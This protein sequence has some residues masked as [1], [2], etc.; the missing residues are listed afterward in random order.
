M[1]KHFIYRICFAEKNIII[2]IKLH[3]I[4]LSLKKYHVVL[5]FAFK[6]DSYL[7]ELIRYKCFF[8]L[9][10]TSL[11]PG[12]EILWNP[13][14]LTPLFSG[15]SG[16]DAQEDGEG[17]DSFSWGGEAG[18]CSQSVA[19]LQ[20]LES[21]MLSQVNCLEEQGCDWLSLSAVVLLLPPS[22]LLWLFCFAP[23]I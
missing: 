22:K 15:V 9:V 8:L 19:S 17:A 3:F 13:Y 12:P 5:C 2:H 23:S 4:M 7:C 10:Q 6:N 20:T 14:R 21:L 18:L 11:K 16:A 1:D